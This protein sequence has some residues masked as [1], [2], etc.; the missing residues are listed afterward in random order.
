[1]KYPKIS[2]I[3]CAYKQEKIIENTLKH[4]LKLNYPNKE[5]IVAVDTEE[6]RTYE[7][8]KKFKNKIKITYSKERRGIVK[9]FNDALKLAKG[10]IIVKL[11]TEYRFT[12]KKPL[13]K[14]ALYYIYPWTGGLTFN[15]SNPPNMH[16]YFGRL[17]HAQRLMAR[18][19]CDWREKYYPIVKG[20][21]NIPL[22]IESWRNVIKKIDEKSINDDGEFAYEILRRGYEVR[23][24]SNVKRYALNEPGNV[25]DVFHRQRRTTVGW[26][27]T[28]KR[29][30][31]SLRFYYLSLLKYYALNIK[32]YGVG[33]LFYLFYFI[34]IYSIS[35]FGALLKLKQKINIT[36]IWVKK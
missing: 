29:R 16:K 26:F 30:K 6:D 22:F 12:V 10:E 14:I 20:E 36:K 7:K 3:V 32:K 11:D 23:F 19:A 25:R 27:V 34:L 28:K 35:L 31:I 17:T 33:S 5:I 8:A 24:A 18:I 9:A 15:V 13:H 21:A 4:L 1:M 2:I